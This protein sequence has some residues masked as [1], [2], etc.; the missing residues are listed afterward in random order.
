MNL[1]V[2]AVINGHDHIITFLLDRGADINWRGED[3]FFERPA[4]ETAV[5]YSRISTVKLLLSRGAN[6]NQ[7]KEY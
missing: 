3:F 1:I 5:S 2:L 4:L 7:G 6:V